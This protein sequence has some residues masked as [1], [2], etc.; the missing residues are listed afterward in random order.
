MNTLRRSILLALA[1]T[2]P[3]GCAYTEPKVPEVELPASFDAKSAG[4]S[5]AG[6]KWQD[7]FADEK[8]N[9]L[10]ATA[11]ESNYDL[12]V[13]L[14][15]IEIARASIRQSTGAV[16]PQVSLGAGAG[17]RKFG[18]YT[19]DGAGNATTDITP[20]RRV[21]V[22]YPDF[23]IGL[24]ASWEIDLWGK[25]RSMRSSARA[26]YL[27]TIEGTNLVITILVSEVALAYFEL[28]ALDHRTD[29]LAQTVAR[30]TQS[31]EI[32][33]LQKEAGRANELGV[34]QFEGQ[35]AS[36]E[37]MVAATLRQRK[38][39]EN[40]INLL[41]GRVPQP[42]VRSK[43]LLLR[44]V[45]AGISLGIPSDL[46]E[47]R[48]DIREAELQVQATKFDVEAARKAFYPSLTLSAGV[49]YQA[50]D[51][52]FLFVTPES[53]VY[54]AVGGI[55]AP[56]LNRSGLEAQ[57]DTSKAMQVQAMYNYQG[58]IL[59]AFVEVENALV[60]VERTSEVVAQKKRQKVAV[61]GTVDTADAL[62]RAG[63]A[64]YLDVLL[65]QQ[66]TLEAELELIDALLEQRLAG[67]GLYRALG[68]G[69]HP[70]TAKPT[71]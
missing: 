13:A 54:S 8:L 24:Q 9:A 55:T 17:V 69:L 52:R 57:L 60:A 65:A 40:Q 47:N 4:P 32:M 71:Q 63:K 20:G 10:I 58:V 64:T 43:D 59:R 35:L 70:L 18:L 21:P 67:I 33:R 31:L 5:V 3:L 28:L 50:F 62:F 11:L 29:I 51:P 19:M 39:T 6:M 61:S 27:A 16:L 15:R 34:Q 14:Q 25:L 48:P 2:A 22:H 42:I 56:L 26:Q 38:E 44:D 68:G 37:A 12:R 1:L 23:V 46:L 53:L 7:Y 45:A 30:Q 49:G 66:N 41:L 36:T